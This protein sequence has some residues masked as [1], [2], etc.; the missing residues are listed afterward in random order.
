[1]KKVNY[2]LISVYILSFANVF[3]QQKLTVRK[4]MQDPKTWIGT[5][6]SRV[7][8]SENSNDIYFNWNPEANM[9]DSLYFISTSDHQVKKV[10]TEARV[11][12]PAR[13]GN[14][15]RDNSLKV[16]SKNGDIYLLD[17]KSG[18]Q[19][20]I[21][22][23]VE[24]KSSVRFSFDEEFIHYQQGNNLFSWEISTG[25]V[26]QLTNFK[27]GK[28][29]SDKKLTEQNQWIADDEMSMMEIL[30]E[31]KEKSDTR[32]K[33]NDQNKVSR[34]KE[35]YYGDKRVS[36]ISL[37]SDENYI[38]Y[39]L[40]SKAKGHTKT[41]V[42]N[43]VTESGY[44]EDITARTNVGNTLS[45]RE[46]WIYNIKN[47]TTYKVD[48]KSLPGVK[49]VPD[50]Y[51]DYKKYKNKDPKVRSVNTNG[52]WWSADG[53][54]VV[55]SFNSKDNKDRWIGILNLEDGTTSIISRQRDEAWIAG[56]G[57]GWFSREQ[58]GWIGKN[59]V[60]FQ[61]EESG[62]SHL[63]T[64][65]IKA[66]KTKALTNGKFE[67]Y[68]PA[69]SKDKSKWYFTANIEH[70][71]VR[72]F[73]S[74][75]IGGGKITKITSLTGNNDVTMS[76]DESKL[77]ILYSSANKP[78]ELYLADNKQGA[79][80]EKITQSLTKEFQNYAWREPEYVTFKAR[81]KAEVHA[82]LYKPKNGESGGP[83]VIFVHG[84]GYLQNAH[85]WWSGY[86]HE[87]MFHNLLVDNGYTVLDIDYRASA[88]YG[89]DWRT[90]IYRH[91]GGKDLTDQVDGAKYLVDSQG[92]DKDKIGIY[93]G[94]YGG[95]I[96]LM[97]LFT[98]P[99]VF[100]AGAALRS[101]TDWAHYNHGYTSPILNTPVEDSLSYARSSPIYYADGLT[102]PLLICHG[103]VDTN[104]HF[105]DV[106]RLTQRLIELEKEEW[107]IA[108]FPVES[109]GFREPSSWADEYTRIFKL[110][111]EYLK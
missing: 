108:L 15:N 23:T 68:E 74:M 35:I 91:M 26:N 76:P 109:H 4:I 63:Y 40:S 73:Y 80:P 72:H 79:I 65:D 43:Y 106:V 62:Y 45:S 94:S 97:A 30:S 20:Q 48:T 13:F 67:V 24:R 81:D 46:L 100:A 51:A 50:Y 57:V 55:V 53:T 9:G 1:M 98:E 84:A 86:F 2:L 6:P 18:N 12:L 59:K 58:I 85:K 52:P 93:G 88:G 69:I 56:P 37:S 77:A 38:V 102:K 110:F 32:K 28:K 60:W 70:P 14:Y 10:G 92:V 39:T 8:W 111:E 19:K 103:V 66:D 61:S 17:I 87:Y 22:N 42:P 27:S 89:R 7:F 5:S 82:R 44:T 11:N 34:P 54:K 36:G 107:E 25:K 101:V 29:R 33:I 47:D 3:G 95:F 41:I 83:A 78:W 71:G 96:T 104:V 49:D 75:P 16:Y 90:G 105:Q 99:D 31:R 64:Y 21:T